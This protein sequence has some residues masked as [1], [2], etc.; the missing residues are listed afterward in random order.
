VLAY[1]SLEDR[2][3]KQAFSAATRDTAPPGLPVVP[4][5]LLPRFAAVTHGAQRPTPAEV[6]ANSRA[7]SAR[8]RVIERVR[9]AS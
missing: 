8:F 3:V 9:E 4:D 5:H 6:S 7:A 1:H 2:A